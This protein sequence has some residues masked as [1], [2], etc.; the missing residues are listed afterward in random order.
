[1]LN[2]SAPPKNL[3]V[4]HL[5]SVSWQQINA[6]P[7]AFPNLLRVT[8]SS[9]R[10]NW[11]ISSA[12]STQMAMAAT[13]YGS[14]YEL[15]ANTSLANIEFADNNPSLFNLLKKAGY[16]T[17]FSALNA[18]HSDEKPLLTGFANSLPSV[19]A[20]DN[21]SELLADM[22]Q[23]FDC[24]PF[25]LYFW[26]MTT[27]VEQLSA[28]NL[29]EEGLDG[30]IE[31]ALAEADRVLGELFE[32][33]KN[34]GLLDNTTIVMFGDHGDD[35][36][37]HGF[38][39][40][41]LHATAP[42]LPIVHTPLF[43]CDPSLKPLVNNKMASSI[44]LLPT[45]IH[46]L[47]LEADLEF[48]HAGKNLLKGVRDIAFS[49][50]LLGNQPDFA[51]Q[52]P[53]KFFSVTDS[54][55]HLMVSREGLEFFNHRLDPTNHCNLLQ[56]FD[57]GTEGEIVFRNSAAMHPHFRAALQFNPQAIS[58]IQARFEYLR[59]SLMNHVLEKSRYVQSV[60]DW[61]YRIFDPQVFFTIRMGLQR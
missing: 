30:Q 46:L 61:P 32:T 10:F 13:L 6:F 60:S 28:L 53:A 5:E 14:D 19:R 20:A 21:F 22:N 12:T 29:N 1:M 3:L 54:S 26:N 7:E 34:R 33:L 9:Q 55:Y 48:R 25:A 59:K 39:G 44:D 52:Q 18:R 58:H 27:H 31:Q 45:C 35:Y 56:F 43:I 36:W 4:I 16:T 2:L 24:Q 57:M 47:G 41:L 15:D 8:G 50:N 51:L 40:G 37:T 49:Q 17:Q 23:L 38:Q 42:Y 11:F